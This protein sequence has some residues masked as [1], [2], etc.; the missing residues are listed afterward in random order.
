MRLATRTCV[1]RDRAIAD[2]IMASLRVYLD[3]AL[4][5]AVNM[6]RDSDLLAA[7]QPGDDPVLRLYR[8]QP[9][10]V[11]IGYNQDFGN[12]N[13]EAIESGGFGLVKRPTG[14]RAI[15]HADE[16][17]YSVTGSSPGPLFGNSLHDSY[18]KINEALLLFLNRL[19]LAA[20]VSGGETRDSMRS[21]VCFKS[22]GKHE[23]RVGG[24]KLVGS[25]Q[26]RTRGVFLQHGSILT[27]KRHLKLPGFLLPGKPGTGMSEEELAGLT[28]DLGQELGRTLTESDLCE[29]EREMA[30]CFSEIFG[31]EISR[32]SEDPDLCR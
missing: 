14:G 3:G 16:L 21:L 32:V 1:G 9:A 25:A 28:T 17:T 24:R 7:H 6:Q 11:T 4:T 5:G 10:A 13:R 2:S 20:E 23:I 29:M 8:W 26:R 30:L 15:F 12:F 27:G 31:L 19:G 18:L 22:A